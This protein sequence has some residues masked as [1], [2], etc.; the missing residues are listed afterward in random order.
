MKVIRYC[1]YRINF[2]LLLLILLNLS[3]SA[4]SHTDRSTSTKFTGTIEDTS[5]YK[6]VKAGEQYN[7]SSFHQWLWGHRYRKEWNTPV[8]I[9]YLNLDSAGG[10]L[11]PVRLGGGRQSTTLHLIGANG[12]QYVFRSIDKS[13]TGAIPEQFHGTFIESIANDQVS[14][15]H[16]YA[17]ITIPPMISAA[18]LYH[19]KPEIVLIPDHER[20]GEYRDQFAGM[21]VLFE[22]RAD[23]D[24]SDADHFGNTINAIGTD[25][26]MEKV[27][28]DNDNL[29]D[30][31][32]YTKTR[33]FDMFV[34]D[35]GRHED[36][37]RWARF[38]EGK[39]EI[40]RPIPRDRDQV[41]TLFDGKIT[42]LGLSVAGAHLESFEGT[43]K[44]INFYNFP[45]RNLD[46]QFA[47]EPT[48]K[49]W[50]QLV[51]ELQVALTDSVI[52]EGIKQLP[53]E[54]YPISGPQLISKLKSRREALPQL[55]T[56]YYMFLAKEVDVTGSDKTEYF[57]IDIRNSKEVAIDVYKIN[58]EEEIKS[59][60]IYS[61]I[62]NADETKEIRLYGLGG[63]DVFFAE[64]VSNNPITIR[65]I[66]GEGKDSV[67]A[68][69][70]KKIHVYDNEK[71]R[72]VD[73]K[74]L[75]IHVTD[76]TLKT[77]YRYDNFKYDKSGLKF[78]VGTT[79][80][81]GYG[82]QKQL[83]GRE[84]FGYQHTLMLEYMLNRNGLGLA[85]RGQVNQFIGKN[86]LALLARIDFPFIDNF[87]GVGNESFD[88]LNNRY[89]RIRTNEFTAGVGLNRF[90]DSHFV[91]VQPFYQTTQV[92]FDEDRIISKPDIGIT[93]EDRKRKH[94][95][96]VEAQYRYQKKDDPIITTKGFG[97]TASA[98][99]TSNLFESKSFKRYTS[100][101][102]VY[103]PLF[104]SL[105]FASRIGGATIT[106]EPEFYQ[107]NILGGST[108]LRGY[109]RRRFFGKTSFFNNNELRW[110]VDTRS[111]LFNGKIG[112][113]AFA[114]QGRLW[115][116]GENSDK[117]HVGYGGGL[118]VAPFERLLL[119]GTIGFS[120]NRR[121][122]H[123][124]LGYLF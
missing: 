16:P 34:G 62:F 44:D 56:E 64:G 52:E 63:D 6:I 102:A 45:A 61:R 41:Y 20:L 89:N 36:Q 70:V 10:G 17:A 98:S 18:G 29:V 42:G 95:A 107:L 85:Y 83:W 54:I 100:T 81:I 76:D 59:D 106:G 46:R 108:N 117:W 35:W 101:F 75:K 11:T 92:R 97:F 30:Q 119:N 26:L 37:W 74:S 50:L 55:A 48:K 105:S 33:L 72:M 32:W 110:L 77:T 47:N 73:G 38:D 69:T 111:K 82:V 94:F 7:T 4:Q 88:N 78:K 8:N 3:L 96:G 13:Y 112:L 25:K 23:E 124:R 84:P 1:N 115:H 87:F 113:L 114:D 51:K 22:E 104:K 60:P 49:E 15:A 21:L 86:N 120:E 90:I 58:K 121:V 53:P 19:T 31:M 65:I 99:H 91:Q 27:F 66:G 80:G 2:F 43:V 79:V 103:F 24:Q 123:F 67:S 68:V 14:T 109:N 40:Y 12:K 116:P 9:R 118:I 71:S 122:L 28:G 93:A 5:L 57:H 39:K